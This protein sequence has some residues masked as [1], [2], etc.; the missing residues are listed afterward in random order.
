M[1]IFGYDI[2]NPFT[3]KLTSDVSI[4][5]DAMDDVKVENPKPL[6]EYTGGGKNEL[7]G[8]DTRIA[9]FK[10]R[11]LQTIK[12]WYLALQNAEQTKN[13]QNLMKVY[14]DVILDPT[15][16]AC[17]EYRNKQLL[18]IPFE[19]V[20]TETEEVDEE[21][22]KE[23]DKEWIYKLLNFACDCKYWGPGLVQVDEIL[24]DNTINFTEIYRAFYEP[25]E[26]YVDWFPTGSKNRDN[27]GDGITIYVRT[28]EPFYE[29]C[30]EFLTK[31]GPENLGLLNK[32]AP[33]ALWK[34]LAIQSQAESCESFGSPW[35]VMK[36]NKQNPDER[37]NLL[38]GLKSMGKASAAV[39]DMTDELELLQPGTPDTSTIFQSLINTADSQIEKLLLGSNVMLGNQQ[40]T[41]S[42]NMADGAT[43][44]FHKMLQSDQREIE[45][46]FNNYLMKRLINLGVMKEG[47]KF[48]FTTQ[49]NM[50]PNEYKDVLSVLLPYYDVDKNDI[51][52]VFGLNILGLK[53]YTEPGIMD[54]PI[55]DPVEDTEKEITD[56][57]GQ[58]TE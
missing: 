26:G 54:E 25:I 34:K 5:P 55:E 41:G 22:T 37:R 36:T 13:R 31:E 8:T 10:Q 57:D 7:G 12:T 29:W 18:S 1:D 6:D 24:E 39:I 14:R 58:G 45:F 21:A 17:I 51:E 49:D 44:E 43:D 48:Q 30:F 27:A 2:R 47:L 23:L 15:V 40:G 38:E 20:N 3:K 4:A 9:S 53:G 46:W 19:L 42:Y 50:S 35:K 16:S 32:V 56:D 11:T 28:T 52:E 33:Y